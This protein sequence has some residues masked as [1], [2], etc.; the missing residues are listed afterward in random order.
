MMRTVEQIKQDIE[1]LQN[2][3]NREEMADDFFYTNGKE[4]YFSRTM[5][6]LKKELAET[7]GEK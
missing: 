7:E 4:A 6:A 1:N 5:Y 2:W 3:K